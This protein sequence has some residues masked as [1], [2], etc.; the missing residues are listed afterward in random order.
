MQNAKKK[1][2][3]T[4]NKARK[5]IVLA[6]AILLVFYILSLALWIDKFDWETASY[7]TVFY[8]AIGVFFSLWQANAQK[9]AQK[10]DLVLL[11][12]SLSEEISKSSILRYSIDE[13]D[14][15]SLEVIQTLKECLNLINKV[16]LIT[17]K[18]L[19][20]FD[21]LYVICGNN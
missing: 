11:E 20:D 3:Q 6:T 4:L 1:L 5:P 12:I 19:T 14:Y 18:E 2:L 13:L 16:S 21:E 7:I 8:G 9:K 17:R 15:T 10:K